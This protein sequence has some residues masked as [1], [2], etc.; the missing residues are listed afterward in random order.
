M[1]N[2][3]VWIIFLITSRNSFLSLV[4]VFSSSCMHLC[5]HIICL[6]YLFICMH[7]SSF[8][9]PLTCCLS[10]SIQHYYHDCQTCDLLCTDDYSIFL[11]KICLALIFS[12]AFTL[13]NLFRCCYWCWQTAVLSVRA[14]LQARLFVL[15]VAARRWLYGEAF[16]WSKFPRQVCLLP[17]DN[18][19][20][21][22]FMRQNWLMPGL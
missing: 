21:D 5:Q 17:L 16:W 18:Q 19:L 22:M 8:L 14:D 4:F 1:P 13:P 6:S 7:S 3:F 15:E 20:V 10:V 12:S 2:S 11:R 9:R